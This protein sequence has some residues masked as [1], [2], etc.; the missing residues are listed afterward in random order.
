M[1]KVFLYLCFQS[2]QRAQE[3]HTFSSW[4]PTHC[5]FH[6]LNMIFIHCKLKHYH[7]CIQS[8]RNRGSSNLN[9]L[10]DSN[11]IFIR[12]ELWVQHILKIGTTQYICTAVILLQ[13]QTRKGMTAKP[14]AIVLYIPAVLVTIPSFPPP[15]N[16]P[17]AGFA[18]QSKEVSWYLEIN[19]GEGR[20]F[21]SVGWNTLW[22]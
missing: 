18:W 11:D 10:L 15:N 16:I 21:K 12:T 5:H 22:D 20:G 13:A 19:A 4:P 17:L 9:R 1:K 6:A 7:F 14:T 3:I 8:L 2:S